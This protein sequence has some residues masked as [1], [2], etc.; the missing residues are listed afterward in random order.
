MA[1]SI[2]LVAA[3]SGFVP[4]F[5]A[6]P[7]TDA[8]PAEA[9]APGLAPI[10]AAGGPH[11]GREVFGFALASSLA[12][13]T[14]GYPSWNFDLVSTV[15][16]FGLH[17]NTVGQFA[18]D[19]GWTVWNSSTL[20]SLVSIA[21]QHG[22]RVVLTVVLQDFTPGTPNMCA[23]LNHADATVATTV[24]EV[25]A[26]HVDG[27][28]IDY[29]GL[30]GSCGT[31]DPFWAQHAMDSFAKKM[32]AGLGAS[33][34]LSIDTYAGAASDPYGFFDVVGLS[35]SVDS[36]FVMAYDMEY[37]NYSRAPA[38]CSRFCL[39]PTAPHSSYYYNDTSVTSQYLA[40]VPASKVI[41]GVPYYGRKACVGAAVANAYPTSS[42]VADTY[43]DAAGEAAF[44]EVK[45]GTYVVHR[46]SSSSGMERWDTWYNT[47]LNCTRELYWDDAISLGKKYDLVNSSA[48][49][50]VGIWNLNYGG[51]A[52]E[53]WADLSSHFGRCATATISAAPSSP[54]GTGAAVTLTAGSTG[55][56]TP[57][58]RFWVQPPGGPWAVT[59]DYS[60]ASTYLWK[61]SG[62]PGSYHLEADVRAGTSGS[63]D[64][65]ANLTYALSA[66]SSATLTLDHTSPQQPGPVVLL[67]AHATCAGTPEYRFWVRPPGGAW[68]VVQ[69][70][71][72]ASAYSWSTSGKPVGTYRLEADVRDQGAAA[73]YESTVNIPFVL[74]PACARPAVIAS[75]AS[76]QGPGA[77]VAISATT[78]GCSSPS[79]RFW[80]RPPGGSWATVQAYGPSASY[81][82]NTAGVAAGTYSVEVDVRDASSTAAYDAVT[83]LS[84]VL[85][86]CASA[87][88][89]TDKSAPQ[90]PGT[91]IV[92]TASAACAG[93]AQYRFWVRPP[94]GS[95]AVVQNY[96]A[97]STYTWSTAGKAV[98][99]YG[100]EVDV[101][102]AGS[103]ASYESVANLTYLVDACSAAHLTTDKA[104]PQAPG[105]VIVLTGAATCAGTPQYRFWIRPPGGSW[106]IVQDYGTAAS[107]SWNTTGKAKGTYALEVDVRDL[108]SAVAYQTVANSSFVLGP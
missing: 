2:A 97:T 96:G 93:A 78:S 4:V 108:G 18:S 32:R 67:S 73:P 10:Q 86:P 8:S 104:S 1:A 72:A 65:V 9:H 63:Y 5:A 42:V 11:L 33:R 68:V 95:W 82:W 59:Q 100:L 19:N 89:A 75:P 35:S 61:P 51:G 50:G 85:Q 87:R 57:Q 15:A 64:A 84:D 48:L 106:T 70:Y 29:E 94:G 53:L 71:G 36:F 47:T 46:E 17:V 12:D 41:L 34:Y 54:Q 13:P 30:D 55:C 23:G 76:P 38:S 101:R 6:S 102:G 24:A 40:K 79:F 44:F 69:G 22:A 56:P 90:P 92:L 98:G 43:Q 81:A 52:P 83:N 3:A 74:D 14:I 16:F 62:S 37:S 99:S 66:C 21:H 60:S 49:R 45:P 26:K 25:A 39:A 80:I 88:L 107:F 58:Y 103:T 7:N 27:V 28:N 91:T 105:A 20:A 77:V 31:S